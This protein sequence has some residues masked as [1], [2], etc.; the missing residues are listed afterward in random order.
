[1]PC[2]AFTGAGEAAK[3]ALQAAAQTMTAKLRAMDLRRATDM[4]A[5]LWI[6]LPCRPLLSFTEVPESATHFLRGSHFFSIR[7]TIV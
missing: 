5:S 6:N 3:P 7:Q 1:M 2:S 4:T